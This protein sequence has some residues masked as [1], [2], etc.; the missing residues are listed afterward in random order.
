M[1]VEGGGEGDSPCLRFEHLDIMTKID[2]GQVLNDH[3]KAPNV[4]HLSH[5]NARMGFV[6]EN[7]GKPRSL[8]IFFS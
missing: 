4:I 1:G 3:V 8:T 2:V 6:R 7:E 5:K